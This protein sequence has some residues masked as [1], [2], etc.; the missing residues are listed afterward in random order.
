MTLGYLRVWAGNNTVSPDLEDA[1]VRV[2]GIWSGDGQEAGEEKDSKVHN[3][4]YSL[5]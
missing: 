1:A 3:G 4:F 2:L 5:Q